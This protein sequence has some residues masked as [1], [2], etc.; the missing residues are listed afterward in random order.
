MKTRIIFN[1]NDNSEIKIYP[2][3]CDKKDYVM[4]T[5]CRI[6]IRK[7]WIALLLY[8]NKLLDGKLYKENKNYLKIPLFYCITGLSFHLLEE[9]KIYIG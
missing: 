8:N 5:Y 1:F 3:F 9:K 2:K 7:L 6:S 4:S